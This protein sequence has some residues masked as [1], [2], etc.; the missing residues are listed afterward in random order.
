MDFSTLFEYNFGD[1]D[2]S[3]L[4]GEEV[5]RQTVFTYVDGLNE[6]EE[7]VKQVFTEEFGINPIKQRVEL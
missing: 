4:K 1:F 5:Q 7:M 6:L 2:F 3:L